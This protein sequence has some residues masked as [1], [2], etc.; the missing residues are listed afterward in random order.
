MLPKSYGQ[1]TLVLLPV[2]PYLVHAYWQ[3]APRD[4][5]KAQRRWRRE[6]E[7]A[8]PALRF[9]DITDITSAESPANHAFDIDIDLRAANWYVHLWSP[10]R[11]YVVDLGF[12]M[13]NR[14]FL[15]VIRSN[16]AQTPPAWPSQKIEPGFRLEER[17]RELAERLRGRTEERPGPW[18]R[19]A[20]GRQTQGEMPAM[21]DSEAEL[22]RKLLEMY[23]FRLPAGPLS[24]AELSAEWILAELG[25]EE[26]FRDIVE[27]N[28]RSY[29]AG[30]SSGESSR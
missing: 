8:Q 2:H 21:T 24:E 29:T 17:A 19:A 22:R 28:E 13:P 20:G 1:T 5:E 16:A 12:R 15:S 6:G 9:F 3:I 23:M 27:L 11:T 30:I 25:A 7:S 10:G 14:R 26:A 18:A 4:L